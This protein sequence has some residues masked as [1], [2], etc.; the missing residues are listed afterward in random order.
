MDA[1]DQFNVSASNEDLSDKI[2]Y[3]VKS[4]DELTKNS[5]VH[6]AL[7]QQMEKIQSYDQS[8]ASDLRIKL[9]RIKR[10]ISILI[11]NN[12]SS[13]RIEAKVIQFTEEDVKLIRSAEPKLHGRIT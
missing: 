6:T 2:L 13:E 9:N 7:L 10:A 4:A 8:K 3:I 11:V 1:H 5:N 12:A